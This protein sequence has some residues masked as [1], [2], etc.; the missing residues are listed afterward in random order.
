MGHATFAPAMVRGL[1]VGF[2]LLFAPGFIATRA[3]GLNVRR[4]ELPALSFALSLAA[5]LPALLTAASAG[6]SLAVIAPLSAVVVIVLAGIATFRPV[7]QAAAVTDEEKTTDVRVLIA[8]AALLGAA[9]T[10]GAYLFTQTGAVDRWWYLAYVR[11]YLTSAPL[12]LGEPFFGSGFVHPRFGFNAWLLVLAAWSR[13]A[14]VDPVFLYERVAPLLLVPTAL[15]A[16]R[17]LAGS[18]FRTPRVVWLAVVA[19]ALLWSGGSLF[20]I[21]T[22]SVEDKILAAVV[23]APVSLAAIARALSSRSLGWIVGASLALAAASTVHPVVYMITVLSALPYIALMAASRKTTPLVAALLVAALA[24]GAAYP[25]SNGSAARELLAADG[26]TLEQTDHPV[27]RIHR[28]RDR[29]IELKDDGYIVNPRLLAHPVTAFA[30]LS[31]FFLGARTREERFFLIPATLIPLFICFAP[32]LAT[33]VGGVGVPWMIYRVLWAIPYGMLAAAGI[34]TVSNTVRLPALAAVALLAIGVAPIARTSVGER[35]SDARVAQTRP[36]GEFSDVLTVLSTLGR[37]ALVAAPP[38]LSERLPALTGVGV[39][40]MSDRATTVFSG[41]RAAAQPRLRA[42]AMINAGLWRADDETPTPTHILVAPGSVSDKYCGKR[43]HYGERYSLCIF[44][45]TASKPGVNLA[46]ADTPLGSEGNV[47]HAHTD[48]IDG[49]DERLI[50]QCTPG[51]DH[52]SDKLIWQRPGPWSGRYPG[53]FCRITVGREKRI[54][55]MIAKRLHLAAFTGA[56]TDEF[57]VEARAFDDIGQRWSVRNRTKV[58]GTTTMEFRLPRAHAHTFEITV[59]PT[60]LPFVKL[61]DF[62][63]TFED[64]MVRSLGGIALDTPPD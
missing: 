39:L 7:A 61:D 53:L 8:V 5:A 60:H 56:A 22:R 28:S 35:L 37:D 59:V 64:R 34:E 21:L 20:P 41:S 46:K 50:M 52:E 18:I 1:A 17:L 27:V 24:L 25:M 6:R 14:A 45:P 29:L 40:A 13:F 26:A 49:K 55:R 12:T 11:S 19:T 57:I 15:S 63:M 36:D 43:L 44:E 10:L 32:P 58:S 23:L 42:N 2:A 48:L 33:L 31:L 47:T 9:L 62:A 30:L 38:E 54:G 3:L 4:S 16:A 51:A